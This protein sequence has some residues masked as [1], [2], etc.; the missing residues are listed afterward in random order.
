MG[1]IIRAATLVWHSPQPVLVPTFLHHLPPSFCLSLP[2]HTEPGHGTVA[3]C[4]TVLNTDRCLFIVYYKNLCQ[5]VVRRSGVSD[6]CRS[7]NWYVSASFAVQA[8][9]AIHVLPQASSRHAAE[10]PWLLWASLPRQNLWWGQYPERTQRP[11]ERGEMAS[12]I[13]L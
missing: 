8:S 12:L 7:L 13:R 6:K 4:E 10:N 5:V 3:T 11:T 9:G 1:E 2:T